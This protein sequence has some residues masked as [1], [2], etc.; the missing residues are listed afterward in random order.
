MLIKRELGRSKLR[1]AMIEKALGGAIWAALVFLAYAA[2]AYI[3]E[4]VK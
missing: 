4:H 1:G 2:W 3:K